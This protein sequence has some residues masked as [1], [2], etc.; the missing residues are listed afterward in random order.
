MAK[1]WKYKEDKF[2]ISM[3]K[4]GKS[5]KDIAQPLGRTPA[6]C[7]QRAFKLGICKPQRK[8]PP[9]RQLEMDFRESPKDQELPTYVDEATQV[10]ADYVFNNQPKPKPTWWKQMMWWRN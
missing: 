10:P 4:A 8:A 6:S 9:E 2:L 7:H 3:R 5:Y 1:Q